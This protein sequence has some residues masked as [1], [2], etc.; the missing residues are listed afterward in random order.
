MRRAVEMVNHAAGG[1]LVEEPGP[2]TRPPK[3]TD[4]GQVDAPAFEPVERR[5]RVVVASHRYDADAAAPERCGN[6][7]VQ[8]G[9]PRLAEERLPIR[10]DDVVHEQVAEQNEIRRAGHQAV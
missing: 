4:A 9:T 5:G 6:G 3:L 2:A 10:E 8:H 1:R 7:G